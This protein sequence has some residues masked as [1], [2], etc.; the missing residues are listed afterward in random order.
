MKTNFATHN[1][2]RGIEDLLI[3]HVKR[4]FCQKCPAFDDLDGE[5]ADRVMSASSNI[6]E[7]EVREWFDANAQSVFDNMR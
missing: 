5:W 3:E 1:A 7:S 2:I 6:V 4:N